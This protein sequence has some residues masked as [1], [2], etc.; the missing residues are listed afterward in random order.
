MRAMDESV[1]LLPT[2]G[3]AAAAAAL[4]GVEGAV[5]A[6]DEHGRA[7]F[8]NAEAVRVFGP[9][10]ELRED[11]WQILPDAAVGVVRAVADEALHMRT[12]RVGPELVQLRGAWWRVVVT[13][14]QSGVVIHLL[15]AAEQRK[16]EKRLRQFEER[17][18]RREEDFDQLLVA[19]GVVIS[20]VDT[21]LRYTQFLNIPANYPKTGYLGKRAY[22]FA[23]APGGQ[24]VAAF[25]LEVLETGRRLVRELGWDDGGGERSWMLYGE[26]LYTDDGSIRGVKT[27]GFE[28]TALR[29]AE[30][31]ASTDYLTGVLNRRAMSVLVRQEVLRAERYGTVFSVVFLDID[32]FKRVNDLYG[33]GVGDQV[34][35][36]RVGVE[37]RDADT[38]ARWGGEEFLVLLPETDGQEAANVA[39]RMRQSVEARPFQAV[40]PL[41]ISLGVASMA[42]AEQAEDLIARAS[43]ACLRAKRL[44]RNG[45]VLDV[46]RSNEKNEDAQTPLFEGCDP[47][48]SCA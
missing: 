15:D 48:G 40:G 27:M 7:L 34:L 19:R 1:A 20:Y 28:L 46:T 10:L 47:N 8:V 43:K 33:H 44:G 6:L 45:V 16:V 3:E 22:E 26:P 11:V 29:R 2:S 24:A 30:T 5:L 18:R 25:Q 12:R 23:D 9:G 42:G 36:E 31:A 37:L 41:T 32:S 4:A 39:E 14:T 21:D 38:I 13:P 35:K 17:V